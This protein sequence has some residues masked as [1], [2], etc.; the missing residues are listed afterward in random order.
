MLTRFRRSRPAHCAAFF[1]LSVFTSGCYGWRPIEL[2]PDLPE[3]V[4][5]SLSGSED[6]APCLAPIEVRVPIVAGDSLYHS[7]GTQEPIPTSSIC[8]VEERKAQPFRTVLAAIGIVGTVFLVTAG[9]ALHQLSEDWG[10]G[11]D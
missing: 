10:G 2:G 9:I 5:I 1:A 3:H 6:D 11:A 8:T 7:A 4:R